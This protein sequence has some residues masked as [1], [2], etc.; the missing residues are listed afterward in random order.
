MYLAVTFR[1]SCLPVFACRRVVLHFFD[2]KQL[3]QVSFI[4]WCYFQ[5][6]F[7]PKTDIFLIGDFFVLH[8]MIEVPK[9]VGKIS[10]FL[11]M[12]MLNNQFKE[13]ILS[14]MN[15]F[16]LPSKTKRGIF[17]MKHFKLITRFLGLIKLD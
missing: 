4:L 8:F 6:H 5:S 17:D 11:Q 14:L 13:S 3:L 9:K 1:H 2:P 12:I 16:T 15:I 10:Q 7:Q